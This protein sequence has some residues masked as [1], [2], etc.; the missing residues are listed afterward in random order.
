MSNYEIFVGLHQKGNP[1]LLGNAW[2]VHTA[3]IFENNGYKAIGTSSAAIANSLGYE[4]GEKISFEE[5][6]FI[7]KRI[8]ANVNIPV[9]VDME[10]GYSNDIKEVIKNIEKLHDTG[11]VGINLED[12][13]ERQL[14]PAD[15]FSKKLNTIKNHLVKN[16]IKIFINAR[17][18][19]FL[20]GVPSALEVTLERIKAYENAG[21]D[22]IFVPF[23]ADKAEIKKVTAATSLPINVLCVP[24]LP[25]FETLAELGVGRISLGSSAFRAT[26]TSFENL[27]KNIITEKSVAP[28]F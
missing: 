5:L 26:N 8:L 12:S 19:A 7:V 25:S 20:F 27:I 1:L 11:V 9:S 3:K 2:N 6:F 23:I 18:D 15:K 21:A 10:A 14:I 13:A 4:D 22:G 17:T 28:L 16:N 24:N